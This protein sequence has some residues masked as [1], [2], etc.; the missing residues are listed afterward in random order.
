MIEDEVIKE[1]H[2]IRD[3]IAKEFDYDLDRFFD[4]IQGK[5]IEDGRK[6]VSFV[7]KNPKITKK[8]FGKIAA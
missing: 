4:D 3:E 5:P 7:R 8:D 1:V 6:V 2:R